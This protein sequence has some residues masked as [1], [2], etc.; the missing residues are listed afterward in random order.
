MYMTTWHTADIYQVSITGRCAT[1][2]VDLCSGLAPLVFSFG[3]AQLFSSSGSSGSKPEEC[4][5]WR[6]FFQA[7][8]GNQW[9]LA[10]SGYRLW[11]AVTRG[12][13]CDSEA[14][15]WRWC[16]NHAGGSIARTKAPGTW[17]MAAQ[18]LN[19]LINIYS[20]LYN[21]WSS[22]G[23]NVRSRSLA[24]FIS[25]PLLNPATMVHMMPVMALIGTT[26]WCLL[27]PF[28]TCWLTGPYAALCGW[29]HSLQ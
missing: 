19:W 12:R 11:H 1:C 29:R 24:R 17:K 7:T 6:Q 13:C 15:I 18:L 9:P 3:G 14:E 4:V 16:S 22:V 2:F 26:F 5:A 20:I 23:T 21:H 27:T 10:T 28:D 8:N 25:L